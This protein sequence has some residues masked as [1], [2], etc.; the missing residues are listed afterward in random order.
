MDKTFAESHHITPFTQIKGN[1]LNDLDNAKI[2]Y[3]YAIRH[4]NVRIILIQIQKNIIKNRF[5]SV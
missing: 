4:Q 5:S 2:V 3:L 1:N